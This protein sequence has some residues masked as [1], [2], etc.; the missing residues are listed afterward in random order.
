MKKER[1]NSEDILFNDYVKDIIHKEKIETTKYRL[2]YVGLKDKKQIEKHLLIAF[3]ILWLKSSKKESYKTRIINSKDHTIKDIKT[4]PDYIMD[5]EHK[6]LYPIIKSFLD[7]KKTKK[8]NKIIIESGK[9]INS[10]NEA[11]KNKE[12]IS[13]FFIKCKIQNFADILSL[14]HRSKEDN[15]R[16]EKSMTAGDKKKEYRGDDYPTREKKRL[17]DGLNLFIDEC[18]NFISTLLLSLLQELDNNYEIR[19]KIL[20]K[21]IT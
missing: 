19:K 16:G 12:I 21:N 9:I 17:I 6:K 3:P 2:P 13:D 11:I 15:H 5:S 10:I 14:Y 4:T 20:D 7:L 18:I 1:Y 8:T